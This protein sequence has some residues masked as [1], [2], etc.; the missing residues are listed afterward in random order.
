MG[1]RG[2]QEWAYVDANGRIHKLSVNPYKLGSES[3][4]S[5]Q[6]VVINE[7]GTEAIITPQGTITSLPAH[8]GIVPADITSN[9]WQLG[10]LAPSILRSL[11]GPSNLLSGSVSNHSVMTDE[12]FNVN[13]I[14]MTVEADSSFD[15]QAFV[16]A[17]KTRISLTKN[18][19]K[20]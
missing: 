4:P 17:I 14:N 19:K 15:P 20:Y 7:Q 13:T 12:S 1:A 3:I 9:L 2:D 18:N 11:G 16:N 5:D 6:N 10:E 8:T